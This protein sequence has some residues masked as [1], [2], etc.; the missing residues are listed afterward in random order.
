[1]FALLCRFTRDQSGVTAI[2]YAAIASL[3]SIVIVGGVTNIGT[4]LSTIFA[5][6]G[7]ALK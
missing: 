7:P 6:I 2:E 1:V 3:L 5:T 4:H